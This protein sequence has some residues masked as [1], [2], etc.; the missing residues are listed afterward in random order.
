MLRLEGDRESLVQS[1]APDRVASF[2]E[3]LATNAPPMQGRLATRVRSCKPAMAF[4]QTGRSGL[5]GRGPA[6]ASLAPPRR[7][8]A[9]RR[10]HPVAPLACTCWWNGLIEARFAAAALNPKAR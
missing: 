6:A 5:A 7:D 9:P 3:V 1:A 4:P 8:A 10:I 2:G